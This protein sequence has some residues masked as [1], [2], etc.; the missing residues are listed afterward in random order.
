MSSR[1]IVL[2]G[3][4]SGASL[5]RDPNLAGEKPAKYGAR[6]FRLFATLL[7]GMQFIFMM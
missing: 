4:L 1:T 3:S 5:L 6:E 2:S 7:Q